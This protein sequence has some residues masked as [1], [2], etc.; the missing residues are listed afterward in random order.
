MVKDT[1][2]LPAQN[3]ERTPEELNAQTSS[4]V[5]PQAEEPTEK[6]EKEKEGK[7]RRRNKRGQSKSC[8]RSNG[9]KSCGGNR[10]AKKP[11]SRVCCQ[12]RR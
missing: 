12:R 3:E 8:G 5:N 7:R 9:K 4:E 11:V 2:N 6:N 1:T 10:N